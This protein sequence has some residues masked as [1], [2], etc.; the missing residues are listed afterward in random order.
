MAVFWHIQLWSLLLLAT[1]PPKSV[2][3]GAVP[4]AQPR[5]FLPSVEISGID[6]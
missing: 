1:P 3:K 5:Y 4:M 6:V 2:S